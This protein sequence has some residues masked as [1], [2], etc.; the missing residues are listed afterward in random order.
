ML[1]RIRAD[2]RRAREKMARV[3]AGLWNDDLLFAIPDGH[4][5]TETSS[6]IS[7]ESGKSSSSSSSFN[8]GGIELTAMTSKAGGVVTEPEDNPYALIKRKVSIFCLHVPRRFRMYW[9]EPCASFF[10]I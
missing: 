9:W 10:E 8:G 7:A 4:N 6:F 5:D 1:F 3:S 2:R